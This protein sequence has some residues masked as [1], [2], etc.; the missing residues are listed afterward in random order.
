MKFRYFLLS[1]DDRRV[2]ANSHPSEERDTDVFRQPH[3]M[4]VLR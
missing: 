4:S 2:V 3:C 1:F